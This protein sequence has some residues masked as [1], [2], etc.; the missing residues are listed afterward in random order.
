MI[1]AIAFVLLLIL[2]TIPT[3]SLI[4]AQRVDS[5]PTPTLEAVS[6]GPADN[7]R[8]FLGWTLPGIKPNS[9][10]TI[11]DYGFRVTRD[12][13][14]V[15]EFEPEPQGYTA[16]TPGG[17]IEDNSV[18][19]NQTYTY[20]VIIFDRAGNESAPA[21]IAVQAI[22]DDADDPKD[23]NDQSQLTFTIDET[24]SVALQWT[25]MCDADEYEIYRIADSDDASRVLITTGLS[26]ETLR[27]TDHGVQPGEY[28]YEV[29][30]YQL[31]S[32]TPNLDLPQVLS[33]FFIGRAQ[34]QTPGKQPV[35][36]AQATVTVPGAKAQTPPIAQTPAGGSGG[37][38][39]QGLID[40][41]CTIQENLEHVYPIAVRIISVLAF[42]AVIY[43]GYLYITSFGVPARLD[44]AKAWLWSA[45]IGVTLIILLPV[46]V[47]TI[48]MLNKRLPGQ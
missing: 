10:D 42:L 22:P 43:A 12:G 25:A 17:W 15:I 31:L 3:P 48:E 29:V 33:M 20:Q 6:Y 39:N 16:G 38:T 34:A 47:R 41:K 45:I 21:T 40:P 4:F 11:E 30:G 46:I 35:G 18:T 36:K 28:L 14:P 5:V 1:N 19:A 23:C 32:D 9:P 27:Y 26:K 13:S 2:T 44:E 37:C 8:I 24:K 7:V